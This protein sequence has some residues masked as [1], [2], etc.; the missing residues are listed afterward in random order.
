ML[1]AIEFNQLLAAVGE[2]V[3]F[4]QAKPPAATVATHAIVQDI[5]QN[6]SR[7]SEAIVNA[8]GLTGR[9]VQMNMTGLAVPP[10]KFDT[11]IRSNGE[12]ITLDIVNPEH[13]RVSGTVSYYIAYG[14]ASA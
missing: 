10:E 14:K 8:Y 1:T 12:R 2:P 13:A 4:V 6:S 3:T 11:I 5:G 7:A 9:S